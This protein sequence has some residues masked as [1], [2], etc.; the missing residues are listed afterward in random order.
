VVLVSKTLKEYEDLL[1][2]F[3]FVRVHQSHLINVHQVQSYVKSDGGYLV[4]SDG[5]RVVVS[6]HKKDLLLAAL[7]QS[8]IQ[9]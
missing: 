9:L 7:K 2:E 5:S 1:Q 3:G 8:T 4:M 6:R